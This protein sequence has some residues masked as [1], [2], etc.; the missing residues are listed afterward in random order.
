MLGRE[1]LRQ[2]RRWYRQYG[3]ISSGGKL[4]TR[5]AGRE[6]LNSFILVI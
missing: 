1:G 5:R 3:K 2:K 4:C 6:N